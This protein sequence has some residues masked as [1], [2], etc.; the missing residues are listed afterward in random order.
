MTFLFAFVV[1]LALGVCGY[2]IVRGGSPE[3]LTALVILL[4][5]L[6]HR[7]MELI[8]RPEPF[9]GLSLEQL[10]PSFALLGF[11][12][13]LC[14]KANRIWPLFFAA[15]Q[16]LRTIGHVAVLIK[17]DGMQLAYWAMTQIPLLASV[18]VLLLGA[19]ARDIRRNRKSHE[20]DW[21]GQSP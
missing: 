21:R 6:F 16:F 13:W 20:R 9:A 4:E 19:V 8:G 7:L 5:F 11:S 14:I 15:L 10:I 18:F 12:I 1:L 2:A 3:R 17:P